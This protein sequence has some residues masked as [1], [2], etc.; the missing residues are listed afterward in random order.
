MKR[1]I[2]AILLA[3]VAALAIMGLMMT[4]VLL[5]AI[6]HSY[7]EAHTS[8]TGGQVAF[9]NAFV[10]TAILSFVAIRGSLKP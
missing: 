5:L 8:L 9:L 1:T 4:G 2:Y 10:V 6:S 7:L 3:P